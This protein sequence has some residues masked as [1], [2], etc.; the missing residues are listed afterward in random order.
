MKGEPD[1]Y[2]QQ[3][4]EGEPERS[5]MPRIEEMYAFVAEDK[6]PDDEGIIGFMAETGWM[7]MV[8]ADMARVESLKPIAQHV[9][10]ATG[11]KIKLLRFTKREELGPISAEE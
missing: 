2:R 8:G 6:G 9:A 1:R 3:I 4:I 11:K 7:P 5:L 10:R